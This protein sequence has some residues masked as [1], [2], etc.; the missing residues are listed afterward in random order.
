MKTPAYYKAGGF[1][2]KNGK[3]GKKMAKKIENKGEK[4][5]DSLKIKDKGKV[6]MIAH[7]GLSALQ[8]ENTCAAFLAAAKRSY[9]G[10]E[11]DIRLTADGKFA[12]IHDDNLNRVF[13]V[14]KRVRKATLAELRSV[15]G[16]VDG[17]PR[18]DFQIPVLKEFLGI[19]R[20]YQKQAVIEIKDGLTQGEAG[21]LVAEVK[22]EN[23]LQ[24]TIF[25]SFCKRNLLRIKKVYPQANIQW[26]RKRLNVFAFWVALRNKMDLAVRKTGLNA[27]MVGV[28]LQK[29]GKIN[30]WTVDTEAEFTAAK[31]LGVAYVTT[32]VLE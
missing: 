18:A 19:C 8:P 11:T 24:H 30:V 22:K 13:G 25:I 32:N 9:Y 1:S 4:V 7:R 16:M 21:A 23:A 14:R 17:K 15:R 29:G 10:I 20:A 3:F 5:I 31:K 27:Y 6:K 2:F 12:L 28:F 26:L